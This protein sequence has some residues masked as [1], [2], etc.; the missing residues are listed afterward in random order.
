MSKENRYYADLKWYAQDVVD[1]FARNGHTI[2]EETAEEWLA[3][4]EG[5]LLD[6]LCEFGWKV[7]EDL[8]NHTY[9]SRKKKSDRQVCSLCGK[10]HTL[11]VYDNDNRPICL[12]CEIASDMEKTE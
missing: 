8:M 3:D 10:P 5:F 6:Q 7:M 12:P 11:W 9:Q 4:N 1:L 2:S